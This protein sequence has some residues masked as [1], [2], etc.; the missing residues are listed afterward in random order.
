[1]VDVLLRLLTTVLCGLG[2]APSPSDQPDRE[3]VR[4]MEG[5]SRLAIGRALDRLP[6]GLILTP[7]QGTYSGV[8][9]QACGTVRRRDPAPTSGCR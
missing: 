3:L 5:P 6:S 7:D 9:E 8:S 1:M 2:L 4:L